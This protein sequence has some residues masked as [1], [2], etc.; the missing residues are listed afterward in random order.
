M[1]TGIGAIIGDG[2][3]EELHEVVVEGLFVVNS[4][5]AFYGCGCKKPAVGK[6]FG[7][8]N[9]CDISSTLHKQWVH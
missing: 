5:I 9:N 4:G 8:N 3:F 2:E 7:F 1:K 6:C